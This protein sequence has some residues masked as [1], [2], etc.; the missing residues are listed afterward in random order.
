ML[1]VDFVKG[2][3]SEYHLPLT[4]PPKNRLASG[5]GVAQSVAPPPDRNVFS[6]L[7][8]QK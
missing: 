2:E 4:T 1:L 6:F 5:G 7:L 3:R 8:H